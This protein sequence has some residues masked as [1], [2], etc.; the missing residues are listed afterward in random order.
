MSHLSNSNWCW[1]TQTMSLLAIVFNLVVVGNI[2]SIN[3]N[4]KIKG[5]FFFAAWCLHSV[6]SCPQT[7]VGFLP[8]KLFTR[9]IEALNPQFFSKIFIIKSPCMKPTVDLDWRALVLIFE[10]AV[11]AQ[12]CMFFTERER[13]YGSVTCGLRVSYGLMTVTAWWT[14]PD[15]C[16]C[17]QYVYRLCAPAW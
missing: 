2:K 10:C 12:F 3:L 7:A 9:Y 17:V 11:F 8:F 4:R 13:E 15:P 6:Y 5:L 14:G 16:W 1:E